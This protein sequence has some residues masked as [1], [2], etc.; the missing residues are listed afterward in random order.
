VKAL[1]VD[2]RFNTGGDAGV[3]TRL[4]EKLAAKLHGIPVYVLTGRTTFLRA[5]YMQP[6]GSSSPAP[7]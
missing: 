1:V 2:V 7:L 4:V 3:G 5:S 6:N